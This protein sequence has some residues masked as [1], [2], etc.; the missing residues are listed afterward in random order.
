MATFTTRV[1]LHNSDDYETLH[2]EM[3][4]EEFTRTIMNSDEKEYHLPE[5]EYNLHLVD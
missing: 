1:L 3:E 4:D 5:A 2:E